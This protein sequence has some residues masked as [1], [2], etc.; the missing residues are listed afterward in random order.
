MGKKILLTG[1]AG[2]I[3]S[4]IADALIGREDVDLVRVLDNLATGKMDNIQHLLDHPKFEFIKGDIRDIDTCL[5]AATTMD[6][7]CHQAA[8]G[9]VP[10]SIE[11]PLTTN[12]VNITGTLNI[13][14]AARLHNIKRVVYAA[15]SSTYGDSLTLPKVE[16]TIGKPLSPYAVTKYVNELYANVFG[17]L[18]GLELI[19]LRYFNVFGPR[20]DPNGAYAAV[21]P[22]FAKAVIDQ[23]PPFINGDG[24]QSRDF[25]Y[26]LNV[27]QI[28]QLALFT[29]NPNAVNQVYNVALGERIT[30]NQMWHF[31]K[32]L[33]NS[34]IDA[35]Y[36]QARQGDVRD[37]LADISK[38]KQL[39]GYNPEIN[40]FEGLKLAFNWYKK[41]LFQ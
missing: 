3:G 10:R 39:L 1:G 26:V 12:D 9:S 29:D 40:V 20:Q 17:A 16:D 37:S 33:E 36:R 18:F 4:N 22:L 7:V 32:S 30:I 11:D 15:S 6:M 14:N 31:L 5:K 38:A 19:G 13:F 24:E 27:V 34:D 8:L 21:I 25:T 2:F 41:N 28:N 23:I 35:V